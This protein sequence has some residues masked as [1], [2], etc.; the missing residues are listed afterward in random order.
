MTCAAITAA[1]TATTAATLLAGPAVTASAGSGRTPPAL[2]KA[3]QPWTLKLATRYLPPVTNHSRYSSVLVQGRTAWF[4]GGSNF[5]SKR[6]GVPEAELRRNGRW[7]TSPLPS[8][9]QSW[10]VGASATS[11]SDI[12]AV[13]YLDGKVI[14]WNGTRWTVVPK[15]PWSP[16]HQFTGILALPHH[17]VW[18]FGAP[19]S[20]RTGAG[21]WHLSGGKW[22]RVRGMASDL[23][24]ASAASRTDVWGIGGLPGSMTALVHFDGS[25]WHEVSPAS[26]T[27]FS[28]SYVLALGPANVWVAGSVAGLPELGHFDGRAWHAVAVPGFVAPTGMCR[29]GHGGFWVIANPG[30]GPSSVLDLSAAGQWTS[31]TVSSTSANEVL[32]CAL[33]PGTTHN[34]GAGKS[35]APDD[36]TAAAVYGYGRVP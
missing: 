2:L 28:Y 36:G 27:G 11:G 26:L 8:G 15:G 17:N 12:W 22:T 19:G 18:L 24:R 30:F 35:A 9:L 25:A 32:A 31:A 16:K 14:N 21:T 5:N 4:F 33:I 13:T 1:M 23:D 7:H 34:W 29:D 6:D 3:R 20:K 10:I